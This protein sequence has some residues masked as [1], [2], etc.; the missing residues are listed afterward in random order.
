MKTKSKLQH[1]VTS[2]I[3]DFKRNKIRTLLTSLGVMIG[4]FS[5]V[6]LIA[7]GLGLK[8]YIKE[9][10]EGLGSNLIMVMPGN[11]LKE[12]SSSSGGFGP[13]F[14]GGAE[15]TE[16]DIRDLQKI[17]QLDYVVPVF[18]KSLAIQYQDKSFYGY[19]QGTTP[20]AFDLLN[21]KIKLGQHFTQN[22]LR[23]RN[24]VAVIGSTIL[25]ELFDSPQSAINQTIK[26]GTQRYRIIGVA[27]KMGDPEQDKSV[28]VPY[29]S[30]FGNLN[31]DKNFFIIYLGINNKNYLE[32]GKLAVEK[33]LL[34]NYDEDD[35]SVIEQTE[36]L[37][38][39][40]Q[41]FSIIN[42]ILI[43]IGSISLIVGGI[44]I[45]NIMY[46]SVTERTKEIGIRRA[47]GA[48]QKDI[49]YQFLTESVIL[50][51]MGGL[52]GLLLAAIVV[53]ILHQFFP[54]SLNLLSIIISFT[55]SSII[56]VFFGVFPAR[57][58]ANLP[59]IEAIRYE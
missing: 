5:V 19:V 57:R 45:M 59:P 54:A 51:V 44:G 31:P 47:I 48:T 7:L 41:I 42:T 1:L 12:G 27:E 30:T 39:I 14:A 32:S 2:A 28:S 58:A 26:I 23:R 6:M 53:L 22:D 15:F 3:H 25:E 16:K 36:I 34:K 56:G 33:T 24:K 20:E 13:G 50:S 29:K 35:F 40:N 49:L 10:F 55:V 37:S 4:V 38:T 43:A 46:A 11:V 8:N 18:F 9:Q 52:L 21:L 17:P